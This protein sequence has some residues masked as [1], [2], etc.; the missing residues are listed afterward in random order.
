MSTVSSMPSVTL[1]EQFN[2]ATYFLDRHLAEGRGTKTAIFFEGEVFTYAQIA[3]LANRV[4]NGLRD[5]HLEA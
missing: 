4:G 3:E 2:A 5:P 1:P